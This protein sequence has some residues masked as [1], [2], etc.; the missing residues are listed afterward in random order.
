MKIL[1]A[2]AVGAAAATAIMKHQYEIGA[3]IDD[4]L[5][6]SPYR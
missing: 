6:P 1:I 3:W 2:V 4:L 5:D